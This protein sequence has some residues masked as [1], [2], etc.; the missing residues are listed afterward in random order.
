MF[1]YLELVLAVE[2]LLL[3]QVVVV[4]LDI[5]HYLALDHTRRCGLRH[6]AVNRQTLLQVD[7]KGRRERKTLITSHLN[8]NQREEQWENDG[9]RGTHCGMKKT[10]TTTEPIQNQN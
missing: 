9:L 2:L 10:N 8:R 3:A 6:A 5:V 7:R 1:S 4:S